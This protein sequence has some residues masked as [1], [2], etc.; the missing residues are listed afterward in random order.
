MLGPGATKGSDPSQQK[1]LAKLAATAQQQANT[2][3][4]IADELLE[5]KRREGKG[6]HRP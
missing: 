2:F 3:A 6:S 5:L 1:R 4:T